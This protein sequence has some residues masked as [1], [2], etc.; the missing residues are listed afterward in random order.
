MSSKP[1]SHSCLGG[2]TFL[3][4]ALTLACASSAAAA[5]YWER[6]F[7]LPGYDNI[8][9][10]A[11]EPGPS[12]EDAAFLVA[13]NTPGSSLGPYVPWLLKLSPAGEIIWQKAYGSASF[14]SLSDLITTADG[15]YAFT[16]SA[17]G[18]SAVWIVKLTS[19]GAIQWQQRYTCG[20]TYSNGKS[21]AQT[22]DGGYL[23]GG[24][25]QINATTN[26]PIVMRLDAGGNLLW[27]NAFAPAAE[28]PTSL[29]H[30]LCL[31]P[32]GGCIF[33]ASTS[34]YD[35]PTYDV[36]LLKLTAS[37]TIQWQK[38][39]GVT[40]SPESSEFANSIMPTVDGGYIIA[41]L[42][43]TSVG[44]NY[45]IWLFKVN[46]NGNYVW[47][48]RYDAGG[49]FEY[50]A[51]LVPGAAGDFYCMAIS[52]AYPAQ[53]DD[54]LLLNVAS[55]GT[56]NWCRRYGGAGDETSSYFDCNRLLARK[57][58]GGFFMAAQTTTFG[59]ESDF[60]AI[61]T[62]PEGH[63]LDCP[64][65]SD[66]TLTVIDTTASATNTSA[67]TPKPTITTDQGAVSLA[68]TSA[69]VATQCTAFQVA[70]LNCDG[71]INGYDIDPFVLALT[72]PA[73]YA[74]AYPDCNYM[75]ADVNGDGS[76]NGYDIDP[77]VAVL[78]GSK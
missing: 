29:A 60:W 15:G 19:T 43:R 11:I 47:Q 62:D 40:G 27:C 58:D 67:V 9:A 73:A 26:G 35:Y 37:G 45:D 24:H 1:V 77:F 68:S 21:I 70:D 71:T 28:A 13:G 76:V 8:A 69:D 22:A 55:D 54:V 65:V 25:A 38:T 49:E 53:P 5:P 57:A 32:D 42:T 12:G 17:A 41:S 20:F 72:D 34:Y 66:A 46:A 78:T 48:K 64:Y 16:G 44:G 63:I 30:D 33:A 18:D 31:T 10:A 7:G 50:G 3:T 6:S 74:A 23:I 75:L 39:Y 4:L 59:D 14:D 51:T 36:W 2:S 61:S 52:G 56:L